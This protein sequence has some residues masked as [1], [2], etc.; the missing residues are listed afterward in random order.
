MK[1]FCVLMTLVFGYVLALH[2]D[3]FRHFVYHTNHMLNRL[4]EEHLRH[5]ITF[6]ILDDMHIEAVISLL[7]APTLVFKDGCGNYPDDLGI[8]EQHILDRLDYHANEAPG[9]DDRITDYKTLGGM[10]IDRRNRI[11]G[12][13]LFLLRS[14]EDLSNHFDVEQKCRL[15]AL[16]VN[17][18]DPS[19]L[20]FHSYSKQFKGHD[21][22]RLKHYISDDKNQVRHTEYRMWEDGYYEV[23][24][25][26]TKGRKLTPKPGHKIGCVIS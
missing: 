8:K 17:V 16:F 11:K 19:I 14:I 23:I 20:I 10:G 5:L 18:E 26:H 6:Y 1:H 9:E 3:N 12:S 13:V 15:V 4:N 2:E 7:A 21:Y 25:H 24:D 22:C